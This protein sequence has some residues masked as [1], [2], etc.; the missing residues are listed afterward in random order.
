MNRR[1]EDFSAKYGHLVIS[2]L[3]TLYRNTDRS[4]QSAEIELELSSFP[5]II[6]A[7]LVVGLLKVSRGIVTFS[8]GP[9]DDPSLDKARKI[10]SRTRSGTPERIVGHNITGTAH[11]YYGCPPNGGEGN[12][13]RSF[14]GQ[15][16][17]F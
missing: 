6:S 7:L 17:E 2:K 13:R 3:P 8:G 4:K 9:V 1:K 16:I 10:I 12:S 14:T 5:W 11:D 15:A